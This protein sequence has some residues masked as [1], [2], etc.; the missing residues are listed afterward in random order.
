MSDQFNDPS[1]QV[2]WE[3]AGEERFLLQHCLDC[4]AVQH[5]PRAFCVR[6][7][8]DHIDWRDASGLGVVYSQTTVRIPLDASLDQPYV[9]AIVQLEEGPRLLTHLVDGALE[10][11]SPVRLRWRKRDGRPPL[12][13]FGPA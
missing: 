3:A 1:A 2:F 4:G 13:I 7:M 8:S 10:I 11:G 9:V 5:Y 6:C 12:P